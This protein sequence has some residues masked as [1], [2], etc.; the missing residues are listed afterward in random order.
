MATKSNV[1]NII[2]HNNNDAEYHCYGYTTVA[3]AKPVSYQG[4]AISGET[5]DVKKDGTTVYIGLIPESDTYTTYK[6]PLHVKKNSVVYFAQTQTINS[7]KVVLK[8]TTHQRIKFVCNS[9]TTYSSYTDDTTLYINSGDGYTCEMIAD[10]GYTKGSI[11]GASASG[12]VTSNMTIQGDSTAPATA[13]TYT[14]T[15]DP[16][17]GST[18]TIDGTSYSSDS[19]TKTVSVT[20]GSTF[21]VAA[22]SSDSE[23]YSVSKVKVNGSEKA[24]TSA[25]Y[26]MPA[27]NITVTTTG[28]VSD[29]YRTI[30][31]SDSNTSTTLTCNGSNVTSGSSILGRSTVNYSSTASTGY[32][33]TSVTVGS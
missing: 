27:S 18:I 22:A 31:I 14:I 17:V 30:T 20:Y 1:V 5:W 13:N 25:S 16:A 2:D 7:Y 10:T 12:N 23:R 24:I 21:T 33:S 19:V 28:Y 4:T 8:A 6:T 32:E 26:I 29:V 9:T 11:S 3:E 15:V